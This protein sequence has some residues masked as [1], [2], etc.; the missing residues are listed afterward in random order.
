MNSN[1]IYPHKAKG[2]TDTDKQ[3]HKKGTLS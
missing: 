1:Q 3:T 2:H